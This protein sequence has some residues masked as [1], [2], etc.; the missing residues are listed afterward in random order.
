[1]MCPYA[2]AKKMNE[3]PDVFTGD[4]DVKVKPPL[5]A[6]VPLLPVVCAA[7]VSHNK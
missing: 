6:Y 3:P 7:A 1:M 5:D 4:A 2:I